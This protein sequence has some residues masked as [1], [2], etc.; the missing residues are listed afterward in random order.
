M[1]KSNEILVDLSEFEQGSDVSGAITLPTTLT[2]GS[3][4]LNLYYNLG[5]SREDT[6]INSDGGQLNVAGHVAKY[7]APFTINDVTTLI[8]YLLVGYNNTLDIN[9][10]THL[11]NVLLEGQ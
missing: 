3:Y 10:V 2:D 4:T 5:S 7:N 9:D 1:A 8:N 6:P 11:I